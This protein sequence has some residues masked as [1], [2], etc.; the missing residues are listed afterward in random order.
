MMD[1]SGSNPA[2]IFRLVTWNSCR[3]PDTQ[4]RPEIGALDPDILILQ[5]SRTKTAPTWCAV[6][7][8]LG[9]SVH[10]RT[11]IEIETL[12]AASQRGALLVRANRGGIPFRS[13]RC[14]HCRDAADV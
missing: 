1:R 13:S 4:E 8:N 3:S 7:P 6:A 5:E 12:L 14:G 2:A 11:G 10:G 9:I